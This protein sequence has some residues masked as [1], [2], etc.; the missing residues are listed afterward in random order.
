MPSVRQSHLQPMAAVQG[1]QS[2]KS[3]TS[4]TETGRQPPESDIA[5]SGTISGLAVGAHAF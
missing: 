3:L 1:V 4:G 5:T 2:A